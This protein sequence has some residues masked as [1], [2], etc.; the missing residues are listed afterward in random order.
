[1]RELVKIAGAVVQVVLAA[2]TTLGPACAG[3][4]CSDASHPCARAP[5]GVPAPP[6]GGALRARGHFHARP[7]AV[8]RHDSPLCC[9]V[10]ASDAVSLAGHGLDTAVR[11]LLPMAHAVS[12]PVIVLPSTLKASDLASAMRSAP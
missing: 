12:V 10:L 6:S 9:A 3:S 7:A 5:A 1:M 4:V 8:L 11:Q 2:Q